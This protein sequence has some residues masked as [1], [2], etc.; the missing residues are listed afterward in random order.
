G[1]SLS[2]TGLLSGSPEVGSIGIFSFS[3]EVSDDAGRSVA[4]TFSLEVVDVFD[5]ADPHFFVSSSGSQLSTL[6]AENYR[7]NLVIGAFE[8]EARNASGALSGITL[9]L[10]GTMSLSQ[11]SSLR[12]VH[13]LNRDGAFDANDLV[14]DTRGSLAALQNFSFMDFNVLAG[15]SARLLV[16]ADLA[17][18]APSGVTLQVSLADV[19]AISSIAA[20]GQASALPVLGNLPWQ[21]SLLQVSNQVARLSIQS[22]QVTPTFIELDN[23]NL[24]VAVTIRNVGGDNAEVDKVVLVLKRAGASPI[25][26]TASAADGPNLAH[27]SAGASV[28]L[29]L[30]FPL[31]NTLVNAFYTIDAKVTGRD[32]PSNAQIS[33]NDAISADALWLVSPITIVPAELPRPVV[34]VPYRFQ[35]SNQGGLAPMGY[36]L[37]TGLLPAGLSISSSGLISGM[38]T[39]AQTRSFQIA[40]TDA[41]SITKLTSFTMI[42]DPQPNPS[43]NPAT[44]NGI[45]IFTK[46]LKLAQVG[47][48]YFMPIGTDAGE[49]AVFSVIGALPLGLSMSES[50]ELIGTPTQAGVFSFRIRVAK[51][52][53]SA[54]EPFVLTVLA[55][56]TQTPQ[57]PAGSA[58]GINL[59]GVASAIVSPNGMGATPM[60]MSGDPMLDYIDIDSNDGEGTTLIRALAFD[61]NENS[62]IDAG[63]RIHIFFSERVRPESLSFGDFVISG[64]SF[65]SNAMILAGTNHS[66]AFIV[67]GTGGSAL[68][69]LSSLS[70]MPGTIKD[71]AGNLMQS[72][73]V[74]IEDATALSASITLL[75]QHGEALREA[76]IAEV[77]WAAT[78]AEH[79]WSVTIT[80]LQ[81]GSP[82]TTIASGLNGNG[83]LNWRVPIGL[84]GSGYEL[85]LEATNQTL[86]LSY[87]ARSANPFVIQAANLGGVFVPSVR[88][89]AA[90]TLQGE[91]GLVVLN[92]LLSSQGGPLEAPLTIAIQ[93][94]ALGSASAGD[95]YTL[96]TTSVT[97][98]TGAQTGASQ[99]VSITIH[100]DSAVEG[101]ESIILELVPVSSG[102]LPALPSLHTVTIVDDDVLLPALEVR[103]GALTPQLV[104]SGQS[105]SGEALLGPWIRDIKA[106]CNV[107]ITVTNAGDALLSL[108]PAALFGANSGDFSLVSNLPIGLPPNPS[109]VFEVSFTPQALGN[110]VASVQFDHGD[111]N[112][113]QPFVVNLS[114]QGV[115]LFETLAPLTSGTFLD[116][117]AADLLRN[118][119]QQIVSSRANGAGSLVE[120]RDAN[121][122]LLS[123]LLSAS[124]HTQLQILDVE[125]DTDLDVLAYPV[126]GASGPV[127]LI[128]NNN[129]SF[130][131]S[132]L[133]TPASGRISSI[134]GGE[135]NG[136]GRFDLILAGETINQVLWMEGNGDGTF[137][138]PQVLASANEP[139]AL[140]AFDADGNG[141]LD[142]HVVERSTGVVATHFGDG[143]GGVASS[144]NVATGALPNLME[145][146]DLNGDGRRDLVVA[147]SDNGSAWVK[148]FHGLGAAGF[149]LTSTWATTSPANALAI[150]DI[151]ESAGLD[152]GVGFADG[153]EVIF[154]ETSRKWISA[155]AEA[156][157]LRGFADLNSDSHIDA[158]GIDASGLAMV[159]NQHRP[160]CVTPLPNLVDLGIVE[161]ERITYVDVNGDGIRD[162]VTVDTPA[163]KVAVA[164]GKASGGFRVAQR[165][166]VGQFVGAG[167]ARVVAADVNGD[168]RLD[169]VSLN[170]GEHSITTLENLFEGGFGNG[171]NYPA[172]SD[173]RDIVTLDANRDGL[174]DVLVGGGGGSNILV[175]IN[176]GGGMYNATLQPMGRSVDRILG[177]DFNRDGRLDIVFTTLTGG[178]SV[179]AGD[180]AGVFAVNGRVDLLGGSV[181]RIAV[182]D[183]N[184]DGWLD[185]LGFTRL[186]HTLTMWQ[187]QALPTITFGSAQNSSVTPALTAI[188][189]GDF[190]RDGD[191]DLLMIGQDG[192]A[193]IITEIRD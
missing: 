112:Q 41:R 24:P 57:F 52:G 117:K 97:F 37:S 171:L 40:A 98:P 68:A 91:S 106:R 157:A 15:S 81:N 74:V 103:V 104:S 172:P 107:A 100:E 167:P 190:D 64:G 136:D 43:V 71:F 85:L 128:L 17:G 13:D 21:G 184:G 39:T 28:A 7:K 11:V 189:I 191:Q 164:L 35:L 87:T 25:E 118:G 144:I 56:P 186:G 193:G 110:R 166:D 23:A 86:S 129:G 114:G 176:L 163:D 20:L 92:V 169:L 48:E 153:F 192:Q 49:D 82:V 3:I 29:N 138:T 30:S 27:L 126:E 109:V 1:V 36:A 22:T 8:I 42:V 62:A 83:N 99:P 93:D 173:G 89:N 51:D 69:Q 111:A 44:R 4:R 70:S 148:V 32:T 125:G 165:Y 158:L 187:N 14:L 26:I 12:I 79:D 63:D 50:G 145:S 76:E 180:G 168:G 60:P 162:Q 175:L 108:D 47:V 127:T 134:A 123:T 174:T 178:V 33:D 67:L 121:G 53:L 84:A 65:G 58:S 66:E 102:V 101:D 46:T 133:Y 72:S 149:S 140:A 16:V 96:G 31:P 77:R 143:S 78:P 115:E 113:P 19:N 159:A 18:T 137:N 183:R 122:S 152:I 45:A 10:G 73:S 160:Y 59:S 150:A 94:T 179:V 80:L 177:G 139:S 5:P 119:S 154:N 61:V 75:S 132:T 141:S 188:E 6:A 55:S 90:S 182:A 124:S 155:S 88:F 38:P 156:L 2:D 185:V 9:G 131:S 181:N 146:A 54:E 130:T 34:S 135:W 161:G 142:I 105:A 151:D 170:T 95:D 116:A 120:L 147:N